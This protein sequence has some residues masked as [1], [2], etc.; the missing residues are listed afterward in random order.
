MPSVP[1][2]SNAADATVECGDARTIACR[3]TGDKQESNAANAANKIAVAAT[4]TTKTDA[5]MGLGPRCVLLT[6]R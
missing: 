4:I 2:K 3:Q 1:P 6:N 5:A